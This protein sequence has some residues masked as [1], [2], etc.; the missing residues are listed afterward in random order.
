MKQNKFDQN[1]TLKLVF[2]QIR[3]FWWLYNKATWFFLSAKTSPTSQTLCE[4]NLVSIFCQRWFCQ[5]YNVP[6]GWH[7]FRWEPSIR[8]KLDLKSLISCRRHKSLSQQKNL[9][10]FPW[11]KL[12][13]YR[14]YGINLDANDCIWWWRRINALYIYILSR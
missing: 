3:E 5:F 1:G 2:R 12:I 6:L 9:M 11:W 14:I 7:I 13:F 8:D 4:K 10:G